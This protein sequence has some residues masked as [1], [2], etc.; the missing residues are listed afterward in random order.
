MID[1]YPL[2]VVVD[3]FDKNVKDFT[4]V[5][6]IETWVGVGGHDFEYTLLLFFIWTG[7]QSAQQQLLSDQHKSKILKHS[8]TTPVIFPTDAT[9]GQQ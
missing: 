2:F 4:D 1:I 3:Q 8:L 5:N 6:R 7:F 9:F